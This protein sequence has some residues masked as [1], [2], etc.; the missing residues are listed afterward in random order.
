MRK[1]N[2]A[3]RSIRVTV[4][5]G[6]LNGEVCT[7][8][9]VLPASSPALAAY[10][11]LA[12]KCGH[13]SEFMAETGEFVIAVGTEVVVDGSTSDAEAAAVRAAA[14]GQVQNRGSD[15]L[16]GMKWRVGRV[17]VGTGVQALRA[18]LQPVLDEYEKSGSY[19]D[20]DPDNVEH[21]VE[22]VKDAL[23]IL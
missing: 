3:M 13:G 20:L 11:L 12:V 21:L 5:F 2:A 18:N 19:A 14:M 4:T 6:A 7:E 17:I 8:S 15:L 22:A 23:G 10:A 1:G 16:P 9:T